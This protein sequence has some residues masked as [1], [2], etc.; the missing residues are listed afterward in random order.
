MSVATTVKAATTM[1]E[2]GPIALV[3]SAGGYAWWISGDVTSPAWHILD[4]RAL[5]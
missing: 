1:I 4:L 5:P 3:N 2:V